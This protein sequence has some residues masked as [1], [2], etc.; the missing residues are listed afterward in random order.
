MAQVMQTAPFLHFAHVP[1]VAVS[2]IEQQPRPTN[3]ATDR[4][5]P[6]RL[7]PGITGVW[8]KRTA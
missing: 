5:I 7:V 4:N 6:F 2:P 8:L 3:S 1:S